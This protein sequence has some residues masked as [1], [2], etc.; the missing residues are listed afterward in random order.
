MTARLILPLLI[1][2]F[3]L[4]VSAL[5]FDEAEIKGKYEIAGWDPGSTNASPDYTGTATLTPWGQSWKFRAAMDD[6]PYV[7]VGVFD[8]EIGVLSIAFHSL[9]DKENGVTQLRLE[10]GE[11]KGQWTF[12]GVGDGRQGKEIWTKAQ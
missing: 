6:T 1:L 9:D 3:I 12:E 5:A 11:L 7:G 8:A 2:T 4:P 10:D